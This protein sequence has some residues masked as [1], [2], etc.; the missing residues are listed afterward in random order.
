MTCGGWRRKLLEVNPVEGETVPRML[1][2][3][4]SPDQVPVEV[5]LNEH[6]AAGD[7]ASDH[8]AAQL[9]ERIAWALTDAEQAEQRPVDQRGSPET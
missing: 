6:L 4:E 2:M 3:T 7:L 8:F 1:V 5:M 9:V